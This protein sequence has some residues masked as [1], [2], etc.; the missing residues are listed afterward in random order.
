M[1]RISKTWW[2]KRFLSALESCTDSGR[3]QRGRSYAGPSRLL[4]FKIDGDI[5]R[6]KIRGNVNPYFGVYKEP[7][8]RVQIR[9]K[10]IPVSKWKIIIKQLTGNAGWLSRLIMGEVPENIDQAFAGTAHSLLPR[11]S[12]ELQTQCSCPDWANPCKHVAGTYYHVAHLIDQDPFLLFQL[13]GLTRDAL[14]AELVKSP[15]G[16]ALANQLQEEQVSLPKPL[17][18]R[19][20]PAPAEKTTLTMSYK[21][22]WSGKRLPKAQSKGDESGVAA[23]IIRRE[24]DNPPF[25]SRENSFIEAMSD[26]YLRIHSNSKNRI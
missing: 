25:W 4:E 24:G 9:L 7:R 3:L 26:I 11:S 12:R 19:Y 22:F 2:G 13:R 5:I 6:S 18:N 10:K 20:P 1:S 8:Y 23:L 17:A 14:E 15:L 21:Q 16:R